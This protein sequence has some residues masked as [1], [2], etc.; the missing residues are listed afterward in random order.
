MEFC[1]RKKRERGRLVPTTPGGGVSCEDYE[2]ALEALLPPPKLEWLKIEHYRGNTFP[3]TWITSLTKL[4]SLIL[5]NVSNCKNL[6][7]LGKLPSLE[8]LYILSMNN[9]KKVDNVFWGMESGTS[10]SSSSSYFFPKL[11]ILEFRYMYPWKEWDNDNAKKGEDKEHIKFMPCLAALRIFS[12]P[13]LKALPDSLLQRTTLK[14]LIIEFCDI[15]RERYKEGTAEDWHKI[16]HIPKI[17]IEG[18]NIVFDLSILL[19]TPD[20]SASNQDLMHCGLQQRRAKCEQRKKRRTF[21]VMAF[22][23]SSI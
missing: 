10:S 6:H 22:T 23:L 14:E 18:G 5:G 13:S 20:F 2:L 1:E 8:R 3:S 19:V 21:A 15:L 16:S 17:R 7:P 11:E 4:K 12:C 9:V